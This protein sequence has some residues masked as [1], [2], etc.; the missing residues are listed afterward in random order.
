MKTSASDRI[1]RAR[2]TRCRGRAVAAVAVATAGAS[3]LLG[4]TGAGSASAVTPTHPGHANVAVAATAARSMTIHLTNFLLIHPQQLNRTGMGLSHGIWEGNGALVP[5]ESLPYGVTA[6]FGSESNGFMT[7]T[8]GYVT[9]GSTLGDI[10]L[11]WDN[12]YI[13]RNSVTCNAPAGVQ[14]FTS[15]TSGNNADVHVTVFG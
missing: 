8:E 1:S 13:G 10:T 5:P 4:V 9:Y 14:C 11:R 2:R 6:T 7:G 3:A 12:P 15:D